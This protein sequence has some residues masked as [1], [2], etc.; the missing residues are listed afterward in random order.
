MKQIKG[1][2]NYLIDKKGNVYSKYTNKI[3]VPIK[4]KNGY[5]TV[6]LYKNKKAN[7]KTIHRLV[8]LHFIDNK[9][10]FK[11]VNHRDGNRHN[12][13]VLNLEWCSHSYNSS[14]SFKFLEREIWNK[15]IKSKV[16]SDSKKGLKNPMS[17]SIINIY[18]GFVYDTIK[19][20]SFD[21]NI[22]MGTIYSRIKRNSKCNEFVIL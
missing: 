11:C 4:Q 19:D 10:N 15:G 1:F 2:E 13:N 8:A 20:A 6:T 7:T 18:S 21:K 14:Y 17:K 16:L 3:L 12:N 22:P 5:T 9:H